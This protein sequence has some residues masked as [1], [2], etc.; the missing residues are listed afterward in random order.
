[1]DKI[2]N[3]KKGHRYNAEFKARTLNMIRT[4]DKS[5]S[6]IG[7]DLGVPACTLKW[8]INGD[9]SAAMAE[10]PKATSLKERLEELE[11]ENQRLQKENKRLLM[12][13]EILKRAATW[14]AK[15]SE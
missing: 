8:W 12:E 1:M 14:F 3:R 5:I 7:R 6:Q 13:R 10:T 15:E 2:L 9:R 11:A 4:S